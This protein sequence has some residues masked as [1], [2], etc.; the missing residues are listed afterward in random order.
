MDTHAPILVSVYHR[1][2]TLRRCIEALQDNPEA[3]ETDLF[4]V[5]DAAARMQ[6]EARVADVRKYVNEITGFKSVTLIART[7]NWGASRSVTDAITKLLKRFGR[8][9]FMEDDI[10]PSRCY[11]E[12]M[13]KGLDTY[14]DDQKIFAICG[15]KSR[16]RLPSYYRKDLFVLP[17][18]SPWGIGLWSEKYFAAD[19]GESDRYTR[20][21]NE[22]Q[23]VF[24]FCQKNDPLFLHILKGDS[25]GKLKAADVRIEN[26]LLY[27][28]QVCV[29]PRQTMTNVMDTYDDAMH[30]GFRW[31][32]DE[33]LMNG[34]P[35]DFGK[36]K[37]DVDKEIYHRFLAAKYPGL[38]RRFVFALRQRGIW[39]VL[40]Y[41]THRLLRGKSSA[42]SSVGTE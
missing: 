1:L 41:Y 22:K 29:Y 38:L 23:E 8:L 2:Y 35:S 27:S 37:L 32:P 28:G 12:Y 15:Y 9:I 31:C 19:L 3:I 33:K 13:N 17:R 5:S 7:E 42:H 34:V 18:Y 40:R 26:H 6:D 24:T 16:F 39:F 25:T 11:L 4:I 36:I 20:L 14:A 21:H 30:S 10:L